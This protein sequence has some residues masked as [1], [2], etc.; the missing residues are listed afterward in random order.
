MTHPAFDEFFSEL[1]GYH[2]FPWQ[3]RLA[4]LA[5]DGRWP[6]SIG[7]PTGMGKETIT[8]DTSVS[9]PSTSDADFTFSA[10][11]KHSA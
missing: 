2:P 1:H 7:V 6:A 11:V 3:S 9:A 4:A 5:V 10:T 8:A